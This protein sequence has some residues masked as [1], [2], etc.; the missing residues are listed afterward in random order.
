MKKVVVH[1]EDEASMWVIG[2]ELP[3]GSVVEANVVPLPEMPLRD[4]AWCTALGHARRVGGPNVVLT[5]VAILVGKVELNEPVPVDVNVDAF[6]VGREC[7]AW[8]SYQG[9]GHVGG[10]LD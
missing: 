4:N 10:P 6:D 8:C 3:D 9:E 2:S 5:S 7:E 1:D